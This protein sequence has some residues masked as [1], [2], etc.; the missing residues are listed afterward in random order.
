MNCTEIIS[1]VVVKHDEHSNHEPIRV[2][3]TATGLQGTQDTL[4]A[5]VS[6]N[7]FAH[8]PNKSGCP[9]RLA[10]HF[11]IAHLHK[12]TLMKRSTLSG[13]PRLVSPA[14][15]LGLES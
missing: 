1:T 14:W 15:W 10:T 6:N 12:V 8:G 2:Q 4:T 11:P 13:S 7:E 3:K 9:S 5:M